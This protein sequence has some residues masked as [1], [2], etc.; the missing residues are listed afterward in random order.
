VA[1]HET[2]GAESQDRILTLSN[3]CLCCS[4]NG[5]LVNMLT[6]LVS[7][8]PRNEDGLFYGKDTLGLM[9]ALAF[10]LSAIVHCPK[11]LSGQMLVTLLRIRF[12]MWSALSYFEVQGGFM[13]RNTVLVR[14]EC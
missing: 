8:S 1:A 11:R 12:V 14:A 4:V 3:G 7:F 5:D 10:G 13:V 2:V 6:D 9:M